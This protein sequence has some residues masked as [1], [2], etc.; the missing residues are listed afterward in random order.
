[1]TLVEGASLERRGYTS[2]SSADFNVRALSRRA[3]E[4]L[5]AMRQEVTKKRTL[6]SRP[7]ATLAPADFRG[8]A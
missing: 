4:L 6:A 5:L 8:T 1:M 3:G 7:P 2:Y